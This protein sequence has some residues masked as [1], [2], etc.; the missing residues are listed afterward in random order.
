[1]RS[2]LR[3]R[4][5][6]LAVGIGVGSL[7]LPS[8]SGAQVSARDPNATQSIRLAI[9]VGAAERRDEA[10]GLARSAAFMPD[11]RRPMVLDPAD[12]A[13]LAVAVPPTLDPPAARRAFTVVITVL[14]IADE[15][16]ECDITSTVIRRAERTL[17]PVAVLHGLL[18]RPVGVGFDTPRVGYAS[19]AVDLADLAPDVDG[20][21]GE[22]MLELGTAAGGEPKRIELPWAQVRAVWIAMLVPRGVP[23][24]AAGRRSILASAGLASFATGDT[25]AARILLGQLL[26]D[27][28]CL[29]FARS[30]PADAHDLV[31]R[32]HR[33]PTRCT[34]RSTGGTI[35]RSALLPGFGRPVDASER[36]TRAGIATAVVVSAI[37]A[38]YLDGRARS[39][40]QDYLDFVA[41]HVGN[42][43]DV[44]DIT[45]ELRKTET[46]QRT[47]SVL[48]GTTAV[49]IWGTQLV[50]TV[51][52][53]ARHAHRMEAVR[54][55]DPAARPRELGWSPLIG[56]S[57]LGVALTLRW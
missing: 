27:E 42:P 8:A 48:V 24:D 56:P 57:E 47:L 13:A 40:H 2:L 39:A 20:R 51:R 25:S 10:Q 26:T 19:L 11:C 6:L 16:P 22:L 5:C 31:E 35:V 17:V 32:I 28:P 29:R 50:T 7:A 45:G 55:F 46:R 49:A 54:A 34:A 3:T 52:A 12:S 30:I 53:E 38:I 4:R 14:H 23:S 37:G 18:A 44:G 36:S 1:M 21:V 43:E 33:P 9:V 41:L 15:R